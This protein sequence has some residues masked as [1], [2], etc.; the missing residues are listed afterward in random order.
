M[1]KF[2]IAACLLTVGIA[3]VYMRGGWVTHAA[4]KVNVSYSLESDQL[5]LHEPVV[6]NFTVEN[7]FTQPVKLDLGQDRKGGFLVTVTRPDGEEVQV[8]RFS[9]EGVARLGNLS[10]EPGQTYSQ[11]LLLNEWF[12]F[13]TPGRYG[14]EVRLAD[15]VQTR[16]RANVMVSASGTRTAVYILPRDEKKLERVAADLAKRVASASSYE[17]A[18]EATLA[19]SYIKDPVAVPHLGKVISSGRMVESVAVGALAQL[20]NEEAVQVLINASNSQD[21]ETAV[22]AKAALGK[23]ERRTSDLSLKEKIKQALSQGT[24]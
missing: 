3:A 19:L 4:E 13:S 22:L 14:I 6:L 7:G 11:R 24:N 18:A 1:S 16:E 2:G 8:P 20:A 17:E 21:G 15:P 23:I 9:R 10:I 12:N 5:T